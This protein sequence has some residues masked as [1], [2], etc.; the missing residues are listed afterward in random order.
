MAYRHRTAFAIQER[1]TF[2]PSE[3][4]RIFVQIYKHRLGYGIGTRVDDILAAPGAYFAITE[5]FP[6]KRN[7][8]VSALRGRSS[9]DP[10]PIRDVAPAAQTCLSI[11]YVH[12]S[13]NHPDSY[14]ATAFTSDGENKGVVH[15]SSTVHT[16]RFAFLPLPFLAGST[17]SCL[18]TSSC[19]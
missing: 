9:V 12:C 15:S 13:T 19:C 3:S 10:L 7:T 2:L 14:L 4:R 11:E 16:F 6:A 1:G 17:I 5:K 8:H 18:K